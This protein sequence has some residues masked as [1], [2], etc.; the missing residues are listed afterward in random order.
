ME[1]KKIKRKR[2]F[3]EIINL[4][5]ESY[6]INKND[7]NVIFMLAGQ[8]MDNSLTERAIGLYSLSSKYFPEEHLIYFNK[9]NANIVGRKS[10]NN[11]LY[12]P[13]MATY[14]NEDKFDHKSAEGFIYIWGL[15]GRVWSWVNKIK[16]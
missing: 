16:K 12:I 2:N 3:S 11:S 13:D 1:N 14:G 4:L 5:E 10:T 15:P 8:Y 9:G 6:S 7:L